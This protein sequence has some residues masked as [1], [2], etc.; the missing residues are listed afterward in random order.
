MSRQHYVSQFHLAEFTNASGNLWYLHRDT[1]KVESRTTK[2]VGW[3]RKVYAD[4]TALG[5]TGIDVLLSTEVEQNAAPALR[6]FGAVEPLPATLPAE[7]SRYLAWAAARTTSMRSLVLAWIS[8][9]AGPLMEPP[10]EGF[11]QVPLVP[12]QLE[13]IGPN[14]E[15]TSSDEPDEIDTL[16]AQG[17]A[18][19][20]TATDFSEIVHIN[21]WYF[22]VRHFPRLS[23]LVATAPPN[24]PGFVISDRPVF[25][26]VGDRYELPP[27]VLRLPE[28]VV[29]APLTSHR[30][31]LGHHG[32]DTSLQVTPT[33]INLATASAAKQWLAGPDRA[34]LEALRFTLQE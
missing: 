2:G 13:L 4:A 24:S 10:P 16:I 20:L 8:Q 12:R 11:D 33:D 18:P 23:W 27:R 5:G 30:C 31:L 21:A 29:Y 9:P 28:A 15:S 7:L 19:V 17:W 3:A 26:R 34:T 14:G 25:W 1:G 6:A 32:L 22:Q